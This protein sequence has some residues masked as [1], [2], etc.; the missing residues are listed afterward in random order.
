MSAEHYYPHE[1]KSLL[2]LEET[3]KAIAGIKSF[4][5]TYFSA[6]LK[7]RRVTAPLFIEAGTGINDDLNGF[8]KPVSFQPKGMGVTAEIPQSLAKWKRM[9][10]G[11]YKIDLGYGLYTDMN[12]IRPDEDPDNLHSYYVDQWDW[13][14]AI[15]SESRSLDLLM[16]VVKKIYATL[17]ATEFM[18]YESY[19]E[20]TPVLPEDIKFIHA[21]EL[22]KKYPDL[23]P[24]ERESRVAEEFGAVFII[25][26]G[27]VLSD[28]KEHDGRAPDYDDW[29]SENSD[30]YKGLNGDI[31]LWNP[32][33]GRTFEISSMGVR[34][35]REALERQL[36]I[37]GSEERKEL[38]FHKR[39]LAG[40][41]PESIGGGIGQS[42]LCMF[43][44]R[45]A[46]IGEVQA[47]LWPEEVRSNCADKGIFLM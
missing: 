45:K 10:L 19:P 20:I 17:K 12:A 33:L 16:S 11:D 41:F 8:E 13:E 31:I 5:Q 23:S 7:L 24:M 3:E 18:V 42:R 22:C 34:V 21:E 29:S 38:L 1:Y 37:R 2:S 9:M 15:S 25:G 28:G 32:V 27:A 26:I 35:N 43:L 14:M 30:G 39:L 40:D 46:H 44:L 4:F 47:S 6:Q 36:I